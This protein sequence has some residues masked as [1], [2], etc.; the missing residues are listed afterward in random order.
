MKKQIF[1]IIKRFSVN[2]LATT[3]LSIFLMCIVAL[4][5]DF[6]LMGLTVP[7][8]ILL[9]NILAHSGFI[10]LERIDMKQKIINYTVMLVYLTGIIVGFGFIFD[11]FSVNEIWIVCTVGAVVFVFAIVMDIIKINRD[12]KEINASLNKLRKRKNG[13]NI[14]E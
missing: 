5:K 9:V 14:S 7:F 12:A 3:A 8:E 11:W 6:T 2:T 1:Y 13:D 10:I 4:I